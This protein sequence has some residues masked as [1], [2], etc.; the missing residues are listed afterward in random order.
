VQAKRSDRSRDGKLKFG[1]VSGAVLEVLRRSER[2][3]RFIEIHGAVETRM[4]GARNPGGP[5]SAGVM[6]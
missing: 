3:M 1:T 5:E 4:M 2:S 6:P